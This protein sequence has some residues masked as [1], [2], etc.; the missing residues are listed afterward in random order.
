MQSRLAYETEG[1]LALA[2]TPFTPPVQD[3]T[4]AETCT[5]NQYRV[6]ALFNKVVW[7]TGTV[8]ADIGGGRFENATHFLADL[9]IENL[10]YDPFNRPPTHNATVVRRVS[11]GRAH[12]VTLSNV[13]NVSN[14]A[15]GRAQAIVD[16]ADALHKDGTAY[17]TV[18][19]GDGSGVGRE[20]PKGWQEN[21]KLAT[22]VPEILSYFENVKI[23][24]GVIMAKGPRKHLIPAASADKEP[25]VE[26]IS[27]S[28]YGVGKLIGGALY[29]HRSYMPHLAGTALWAAYDRARRELGDFDYNVVK[30][31][32]QGDVTFFASPDFDTAH[33][34]TAGEYRLVKADGTVK[35]GRTASLWHHKWLWVRDDYKGF[36]VDASK[37]RSAEWT[38]RMT[39][40]PRN[41][42]GNPRVWAA[43]LAEHGFASVTKKEA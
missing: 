16:A 14:T 34:P 17:F 15:I 8:N 43:L 36:D 31:T 2:L 41:N 13:L 12:T 30:I 3:Y 33:E 35:K 1:G 19:E 5:A 20:T 22:Y 37:R 39:G 42:I 26:P 27:R 9:G 32:T 7:E 38:A 6:P 10:V 4:S 18:Y 24:R 23:K 11:G 21:R 40:V 28:R 29:L 25:S